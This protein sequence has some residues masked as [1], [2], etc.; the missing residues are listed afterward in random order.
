MLLRSLVGHRWPPIVFILSDNSKRPRRGAHLFYK[1]FESPKCAEKVCRSG[2]LA[3]ASNSPGGFNP[4]REDSLP[5]LVSALGFVCRACRHKT[6]ANHVLLIASA[7]WFH[8]RE[9]SQNVRCGMDENYP[10][11]KGNPMS[12]LSS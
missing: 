12:L 3:N 10:T 6:Q 2:S 8:G 1:R 11:P 9:K 7:S 4:G 5:N